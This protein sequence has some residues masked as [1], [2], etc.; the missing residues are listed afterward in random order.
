VDLN[1][2]AEEFEM[3]SSDIQVFYNMSTGEFEDY[4]NFCEA[5][6][7]DAEKYEDDDWIAGPSQWDIN[8]YNIMVDFV[9]T[10]TNPRK[11]EL[12]SVALEGK[13]A[14]RRFKRTFK[15]INSFKAL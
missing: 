11:N 6:D 10:V 9:E 2:A 12:L 3:V 15:R 5:E 8:E 1:T 4:C 13:G 7:N 14:F